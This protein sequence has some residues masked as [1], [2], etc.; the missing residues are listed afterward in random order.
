MGLKVWLPLTGTLENKGTSNV[1]VTNTGATV[2]T[3]GKLGS[4]YSFGTASS[5][6]TLPASCMT[7]FTEGSVSFWI[8]IT[9]WNTSYAT[10]F[11]AGKGSTAWNNYIFGF[12]RNGTA[13]T[14][15]FTISDSSTSSNASFLTPA[16]STATWYHI[17]LAYKAGHCFIYVNG[18]L[19][20]D[21][22]TTIVPAFNLI[23]K[24]TIGTSNATGSYQTN[25]M[26]NDL[27]IYD[28]CLSTAEVH[29]LA[30]GLVL[31]YKLDD[32]FIE[33]TT[34]L[35]TS[36]TAGGQTTVSDNVITTSGTNADTYFTINLSESIT[37]GTQYTISCDAEIPGD[38]QWCFPLGQQGNTSL[39]FIIKNGHNEYTFTANNITW[40]TNRCFMDDNNPST[41]R[42]SGY[43]TKMWNFQI[44]KKDHATPFAGYGVTRASGT[45]VY[46]SSGHGYTGTISGALT[47]DKTSPRNESSAHI[48]A[49]AQYIKCGAITTTGYSN[50][51]SFSWWSK[52]DAWSGLMNWGFSNGV[53]LNG[54]FNGNLWNT[55]D[56]ANNPLYTPGT[57]TQVT[58]PTTNEWHHFVMTGDGTSCK[59]YKDGVYWAIAKTYKSITGTQIYINGWDTGTSYTYSNLS[60]SDFRIYS[61]CLSAEDV[62]ELYRVGAKLDNRSETHSYAIKEQGNRE[63]IAGQMWTSSYSNHTDHIPSDRIVNGEVVLTGNQSVSTP[64]IPIN[65]SGK[66]YLYD[67]DIST[68]ANNVFYVGFER[69]DKDKTARSNNACVY[70]IASA[71]E[72]VHQRVSGTVN[73]S[74]DGVN[75]CAFITLRILNDWSSS[76]SRKATIHYISLREVATAQTPD[77]KNNG[78]IIADEFIERSKSAFFKNGFVESTQFIE[79]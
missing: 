45:T 13:S 34:N 44:E 51:Y 67:I 55:G 27:R 60:M 58:A 79:M 31:H 62:L 74:T 48:N 47:L 16:L 70:V 78:I 25:C 5:Y 17:A 8:N 23:T 37:N 14:C 52:C 39:P 56:S 66:T 6:M 40:G 33:S 15:C 46:D 1:A 65:P 4:C 68:D 69:Y 19:Y 2:N 76:N 77:V 57:T 22:T 72:R 61:T 10:F 20:A 24:I 63:L 3:S 7:D 30:Q 38:L 71:A 28:H 21:K 54:I 36:L 11:Q 59:V 75:P 9:S 50:S 41:V 73:L 26:L 53:R 42:S 12:L 32:E 35:V 29:E 49:K 43:I 18:S 64:Y